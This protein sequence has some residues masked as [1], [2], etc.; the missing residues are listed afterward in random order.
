MPRRSKTPASPTPLSPPRGGLQIVGF[1][2][3]NPA[4]IQEIIRSKVIEQPTPQNQLV[5]LA[6]SAAQAALLIFMYCSVRRAHHLLQ[7]IPYDTAPEEFK[8]LDNNLVS[9]FARIVDVDLDE[10]AAHLDTVR[11]LR[12]P[13]K[14]GGQGLP[15]LADVADPALIAGWATTAP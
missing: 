7:V 8:K 12:L 2:V 5:S 3:G 11:R 1:P 4:Y 9:T 6:L 13:W 14:F 15:A 10:L